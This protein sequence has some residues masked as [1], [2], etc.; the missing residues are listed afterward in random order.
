MGDFDADR[1]D[2][3]W[4]ASHR[5]IPVGQQMLFQPSRRHLERYVDKVVK[6]RRGRK[7]RH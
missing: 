4:L 2:M 5:A 1:P 7:D 6:V 3:E